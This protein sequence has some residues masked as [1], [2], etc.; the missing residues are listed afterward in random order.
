MPKEAAATYVKISREEFEDWLNTL[1][2]RW[3]RKP[4]KA[5][6]YW[7]HLTSDVAV[8]VSSSVGTRDEAMGRGQGA[9]HF[10][11]V[12]MKNGRTLNKKAQGQARFNRTTNWRVNW[13]KGIASFV[14]E[15]ASK[16]QFYERLATLPADY[17]EKLKARIE[18]LENWRT[19]PTLKDLHAQ[20]SKGWAL[21]MKQE[22]LIGRVETEMAA[23]GG[24][25]TGTVVEA[26]S[27]PSGNVNKKLLDAMRHAYA[28]ARAQNRARDMEF[29]KSVAEKTVKRGLSMS[30]A[31]EKWWGDIQQ[32]YR[33]RMA[34]LLRQAALRVTERY[35]NGHS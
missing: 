11:L 18:S 34:R 9:A 26:P 2:K 12:S 35:L 17:K 24:K 32:R 4:N 21:S 15:F 3:S 8:Q 6:I 22:M 28:A 20:V 27:R 30:S 14:K 23:G 10:S 25:E 33:I 7:V 13:K 29:L 19:N 5:G 16:K 31:Q 1:G